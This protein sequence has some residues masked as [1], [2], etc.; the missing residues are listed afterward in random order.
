MDNNKFVGQ[1]EALAKE[2]LNDYMEELAYS[3]I[4]T[5]SK[6]TEEEIEKTL[7]EMFFKKTNK[8]RNI[9]LH[10]FKGGMDLFHKLLKEDAEKHCSV[11]ENKL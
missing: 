11:E 1:E 2:K 8:D 6:I 9:R 7:T 5:G 10:T 3:Q 4:L